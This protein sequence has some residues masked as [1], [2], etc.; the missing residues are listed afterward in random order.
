MTHD[1]ITR[2]DNI[3]HL[4]EIWEFSKSRR[5]IIEAVVITKLILLNIIFYVDYYSASKF[6]LL[7]LQPYMA[8][9]YGIGRSWKPKKK[10]NIGCH[11]NI[12]IIFPN[13]QFLFHLDTQQWRSWGRL[14]AKNADLEIFLFFYIIFRHA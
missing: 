9:K 6:K 11:S 5:D 2:D 13:S 8:A 3:M 1:F 12:A 7:I 14:N 4:A 10:P